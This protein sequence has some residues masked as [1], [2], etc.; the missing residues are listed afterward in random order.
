VHFVVLVNLILFKISQYLAGRSL[1]NNSLQL[2]FVT[3]FGLHREFAFYV[4]P[5][6]YQINFRRYSRNNKIVLFTL[7]AAKVYFYVRGVFKWPK[8]KRST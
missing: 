1:I 4:D 5:L 2:T 6:P 8:R 3:L 7:Q